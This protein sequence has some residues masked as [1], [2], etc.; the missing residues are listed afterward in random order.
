MS[1]QARGFPAKP[2]HNFDQ[3]R[4]RP[5]ATTPAGRDAD[6]HLED[7]MSPTA[8]GG[9][10]MAGETAEPLVGEPAVAPHTDFGTRC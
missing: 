4:R 10:K 6:R 3:S 7:A 5:G 9:K 1:L 8:T 2:G